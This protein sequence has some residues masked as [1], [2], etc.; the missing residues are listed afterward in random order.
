MRTSGLTATLL[1]LVVCASATKAET[2][3]PTEKLD[4][5][6][7]SGVHTFDVEVMRTEPERARGLMFRKTMAPTHGMLFD[8]EAV[9]PIYMWMKNTL[10]PLDMVFIDAQGTVVNVA[11]DTV[12]MSEKVIAS[13][14]PVL[15]VLEV[16]AGTA[17]TIQLK[18][19][20]KVSNTMFKK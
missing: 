6:T 20:D 12:P 18:K 1:A 10:L 19:G 14:Q 2:T 17:R 7:A 15:G 8:F 13:G 4:I 9:Q 16:N 3:Q 5:S 11:E